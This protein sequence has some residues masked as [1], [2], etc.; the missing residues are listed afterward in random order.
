MK[1]SNMNVIHILLVG[2][3]FISCNDSDDY[4]PLDEPTGRL[5]LALVTDRFSDRLS[6]DAPLNYANQSIPSYI[7]KDNTGINFIEDKKA[8]LGRVLFYEK[9]LSTDNSIAC[10]SCHQQQNAFSDFADASAGVDGTTG[11]HSMRLINSRFSNEARF[12]WDERAASLEVQTTHPIQDH[13]EMGF[14]GENGAPDLNDLIVKLEDLAYYPALFNWAYGDELI[15]EERLQQS[16]AQF[17]RSIQSFDSKYDAGRLAAGN[18]QQI[19]TNFTALENLGKQ[20]F[21]RPRAAGGVGCAGCHQAPEFDIDPNSLNNG[22]ITSFTEG[23]SDLTVTRAPTLRDL[24]K[25]DGTMNGSLMHDASLE[26]LI[27]AVLHY[28][29]IDATGNTNLDPR[30][31]GRPG[32]NGQQL[33]LS[34]TDQQALVSFLETLA[35][36][37]VYTNVKWSDPFQ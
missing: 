30:L 15:N 7:T 22:V 4:T 21:L 9:Q 3:L 34:T 27:E 26:S 35:G 16:L 23:V 32:E 10:A 25:E 6:L 24:V 20:L 37:N 5:D 12:F 36:N 2:M 18:D 17:I 11:R 1:P 14:S 19:F 33:N 31:A 28:N 13:I 8:T 29:T